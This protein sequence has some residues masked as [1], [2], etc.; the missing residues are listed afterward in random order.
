MPAV[1]FEESKTF[2]ALRDVEKLVPDPHHF[3]A[4]STVFSSYPASPQT[5]VNTGRLGLVML[6]E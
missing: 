3:G 4:W 5:S 1:V 2:P 6:G